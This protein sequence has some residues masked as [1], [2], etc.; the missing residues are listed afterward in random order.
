MRVLAN[1]GLLEVHMGAGQQAVVDI[2]FAAIP[3]NGKRQLP[4]AL[5][6]LAPYIFARVR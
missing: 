3:N 4:V 5:T 2:M 6:R 1:S